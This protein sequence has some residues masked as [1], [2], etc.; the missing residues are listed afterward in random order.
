VLYW[1]LY[2]LTIKLSTLSMFLLQLCIILLY[3]PESLLQEDCPIEMSHG[4]SWDQVQGRKVKYQTWSQ[5]ALFLRF[6]KIVSPKQQRTLL[7]ENLN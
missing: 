2:Y 6:W 7:D 1:V 5:W 3:S 4:C